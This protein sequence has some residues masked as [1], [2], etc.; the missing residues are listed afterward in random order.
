MG[1]GG[2]TVFPLSG[3]STDFKT[4]LT[5]QILHRWD[6]RLNQTSLEFQMGQNPQLGRVCPDSGNEACLHV[7]DRAKQL[8][9]DDA[10]GGSDAVVPAVPGNAVLFHNLGG[11]GDLAATA[12][13]MH[14]SC[15]VKA[16]TKVVLAK[17]VRT[18]PKPF[19]DEDLIKKAL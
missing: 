10:S 4:T 3:I 11:V 19:P 9:A 7:F 13:A 18:G 6:S 12:R 15:G 16:G 5:K 8:C 2:G 1:I 17:F 14:G